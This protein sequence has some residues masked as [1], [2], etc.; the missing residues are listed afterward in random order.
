MKAIVNT[1]L[2]LEDGVIFDG[3]L[4][5]EGDKI[6]SLGKAR[7]VTVPDGAE[8]FDARGL[9]TAPGLIDIHNHG[10]AEKLFADDPLACC[11]H[12]LKHGQTTVLP[13]FYQNMT[14]AQMAE[15]AEKIRRA[16]KSGAGR[17]MD[18]LYMEGP[19]MNGNGSSK[20]T[21]IKV[22]GTRAEDYIPML[23][24]FGDMVR[25]WAI[26]PSRPNIDEFMAYVHDRYPAAVFALGHSRA[27][28]SD[29]RRVKKYGVR[30]QTHH[31]DSGKPK[32]RAQGTLDAGCD[33]FTLYDPDIYAELIVDETGIHM[34]PDLVKFVVKTKGVE[35]I[36]LITDS[37]TALGDYKN[38]EELGI[39]YGPDLNYDSD[40]KLSGSHMT[41]DNACRNLMTHTGYGLCH[42]IRFATANPA[43]MLGIEGSVGT[44]EPGKLANLIIIDDEVRVSRVILRGETVVET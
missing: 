38:N 1:K 15:N 6:V 16:S 12:F 34:V 37:N 20:D 40:G 32:G 28:S 24:S 35:R 7:D 44:L 31:S 26:D 3:A 22:D 9:Y 33:I 23:D 43:R 18:G 39:W 8:I 41:L 17:I 14:F 5:Y 21:I 42:A 2:I 36:I 29:C 19:Y 27:H 30:V 11:E 10:T 13:T 25:V 4:L